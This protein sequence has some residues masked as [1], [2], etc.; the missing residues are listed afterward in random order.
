MQEKKIEPADHD[1]YHRIADQSNSWLIA[2]NLEE[3][4]NLEEAIKIYLK[5]AT[6]CW[7]KGS[8]VKAGLS[9]ACAANCLEKIGFAKIARA[10][11]L[12]SATIFEKNAH[13]VIDFSIREALWSLQRAY[14]SYILSDSI[15][16]AEELLK[17]YRSLLLKTSPFMGI[18]EQN[19]ALSIGEIDWNSAKFRL[20]YIENIPK[21]KQSSNSSPI[22]PDLSISLD[23]F[24]QARASNIRVNDL[25]SEAKSPSPDEG[26]HD[27][28]PISLKKGEEKR[29]NNSDD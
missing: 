20:D 2:T 3:E 5:D 17:N 25:T 28:M 1:W 22:P 21:I 26:E 16:K 6:Q 13:D 10:L 14:E 12:E 24:L 18:E 27:K 11:Y 29:E 15:K 9:C 4:G 23:T 8:L 19:N 7:G